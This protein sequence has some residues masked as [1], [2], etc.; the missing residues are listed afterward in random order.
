MLLGLNHEFSKKSNL[1]QKPMYYFYSQRPKYSFG[2]IKIKISH[3][4]T[5]IS[6]SKEL[7]PHSRNSPVWSEIHSSNFRAFFELRLQLK[8]RRSTQLAQL[9][10][11]WFQNARIFELLISDQ[12]G[13]YLL[14]GNSSFEPDMAVLVKWPFSWRSNIG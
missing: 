6:G 14:R 2:T 1:A 11:F 12:T 3:F 9:T 5:G 4:P 13:E 10:L 8:V 7:F